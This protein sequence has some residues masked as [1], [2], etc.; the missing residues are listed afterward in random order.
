MH[1]VEHLPPETKQRIL[2]GAAC[3]FCRDG[4]EGASMASIAAKAGVSKGTLYN[5][6]VSKEALFIAYIEDD[7]STRM[8]RMFEGV[9]ET[10]DIRASLYMLAQRSLMMMMSQDGI[11]M[12]R[13]VVSIAPKFPALAEIF[14]AA[15]PNQALSKMQVFL[16]RAHKAGQLHVPDARFAAEQF[17]SLCQSRICLRRRLNLSDDPPEMAEQVVQGAVDMFL[18]SYGPKS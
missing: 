18:N 4:Y 3:M 9:T 7:C 8:A 12:Y 10:E 6:F 2:D 14:F 13:L 1:P 5:Y 16:E 15:G 17:F 11:A